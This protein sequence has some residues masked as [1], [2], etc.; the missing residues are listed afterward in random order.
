MRVSMPTGTHPAAR[1]A[2]RAPPAVAGAQP[3]RAPRALLW[4][5]TSRT[6]RPSTV[7]SATDPTLDVRTPPMPFVRLADQDDMKLALLLNVV[8]SGIG[9]VLI[10]GDRGTGKS[11]AVSVQGEMGAGGCPGRAAG[12]G[13]GSR[14]GETRLGGAGLPCPS[15]ARIPAH[16]QR[17]APW[18]VL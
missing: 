13:N 9:G 11:V 3:R 7:A 10:M 8:D 18:R 15:A 5:V 4:S 6:P 16:A 17:W 1:A 2:A 14:V 12:G